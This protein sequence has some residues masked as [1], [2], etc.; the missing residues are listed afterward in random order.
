MTYIMFLNL[1]ILDYYIYKVNKTKN[2]L[3]GTLNYT[4]LDEDF[5]RD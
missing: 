5:W 2:K 4:D 3:V 1:I